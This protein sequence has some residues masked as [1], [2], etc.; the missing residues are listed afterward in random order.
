L[1]IF[2]PTALAVLK[3]FKKWQKTYLKKIFTGWCD[4]V[5]LVVDTGA[6]TAFQFV[7]PIPCIANSINFNWFIV[8][9][10]SGKLWLSILVFTI[11]S[12]LAKK[13]LMKI[14]RVIKL[15]ITFLGRRISV[16][17][18]VMCSHL[19]KLS[20]SVSKEVGE[21]FSLHFEEVNYW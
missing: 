15:W 4:I 5:N 17:K 21:L 9:L 8:I 2:V 19:K 20:S 3:G 16:T 10:K 13:D 1:Y 11:D 7:R 14:R 12:C 18:S 6:V